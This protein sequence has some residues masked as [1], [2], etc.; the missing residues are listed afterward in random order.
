MADASADETV[1]LPLN[2]LVAFAGPYISVISGALATWLLTHVN[3]LSL[4]EFSNAQVAES[5]TQLVVFAIVS[6]V[7]WLGQQKW[8]NGWQ[9]FEA[10]MRQPMLEHATQLLIEQAKEGGGPAGSHPST[11][12]DED[13][14]RKEMEARTGGQ[15]PTDEPPVPPPPGPPDPP[16]PPKHRPVS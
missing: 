14:A 12:F 5:I 3:F 6:G 8:L 7:T 16:V 9:K 2:K 15:P 10:D 11:D 13:A 4:F 1:G